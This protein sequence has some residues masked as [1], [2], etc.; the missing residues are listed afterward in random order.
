M[1]LFQFNN[2]Y[3]KSSEETWNTELRRSTASQGKGAEKRVMPSSKGGLSV[4][5]LEK[6]PG[7]QSMELNDQI[8]NQGGKL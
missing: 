5:G 1:D 4:L 6:S 2:Q 8:H 7:V 3:E